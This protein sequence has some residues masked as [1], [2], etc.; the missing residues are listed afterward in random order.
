[1][2]RQQDQKTTKEQS[3][4][5]N[6]NMK[7]EENL[8]Y[9]IVKLRGLPWSSTEEDIAKF[10]CDCEIEGG[11][12]GIHLV[13]SIDNRP[14]GE[15]YVEFASTEDL[16][17]ALAKDRNHMG[18]RYIEVFRTRQS[19]FEWALRR[20]TNSRDWKNDAVVKLRGL[21]FDCTKDEVAIFFDGLDIVPNGV[22]MVTDSTG[23]S[24][25]EAYV[26]FKNVENADLALKKHREKIGHR[27]IEIFRS[28]I[29]D[30]RRFCDNRTYTSQYIGHPLIS[31]T[32]PR[33][34][35]TP[36]ERAL[37]TPPGIF[38]VSRFNRGSQPTTRQFGEY[39]EFENWTIL[40]SRISSTPADLTG[41]TRI[42]S[43]ER[44]DL[45]SSGVRIT[46]MAR[47]MHDRLNL[48]NSN[49]AWISGH[50]SGGFGDNTA[51]FIHMRGLPFKARNSDIINFFKP[52]MPINVSIKYEPNGRATGEA[53]VE[54]ASN[55]EA[56]QAMQKDK[57][58]MHHRYIELFLNNSNRKSRELSLN[59]IFSF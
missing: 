45:T 49:H 39:N 4:V 34:A 42:G 19:E 20:Q 44:I 25:G 17:K 56:L 55:Y 47:I 24:N 8:H 48:G 51:H 26:Q 2:S 28:S 21:P 46:P 50:M 43:A 11:T 5:A 15:A 10:F 27:Y 18:N 22:T 13:M 9:S 23:R 57:G 35:M 33:Y 12:N 58:H 38:R 59:G 53:D 52:I 29:M 41:P 54:F 7:L 16:T 6:N 37:P 3:N 32:E 1:M 36:C 14:T 31:H 30:V 40:P